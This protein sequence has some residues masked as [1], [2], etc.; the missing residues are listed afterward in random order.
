MNGQV[1]DIAGKVT[2]KVSVGNLIQQVLRSG[3]LNFRFSRRGSALE[4]MAGHRRIQR[5]RPPGYESE[6]TIKGVSETEDFRLEI[7]GRIDGLFTNSQPVMIEEIKTL[8]IPLSELADVNRLLHWGQVKI[9]AYLYAAQHDLAA[10]VVQ[11]CY[12]NLDDGEITELQ[13]CYSLPELEEFYQHVVEAYLEWLQTQFRW[14]VCRNASIAALT[15]PYGEYREGQRELAVSAYRAMLSGSQLYAQAPTGI[16][17]TM[18]TL[19]PAIK[20]L[21]EGLHDQVFYLTA[22]TVGRT[23]VEKALTELNGKGLRFKAITLTAKEKICFTP[24]APCDAEHCIYAR[25]YYDRNKPAVQDTLAG[26]DLVTRTVIEARAE[27]HQICPFE[28]S[29]D[30]S[31][32]MD[33]IIC[34]YNYVFDPTVYLRRFFDE[35]GGNYAFLIDEAHNLVDRGREMFSA[36]LEKDSLMTLKRA[37]AGSLPLVA[38]K[39]EKVN[40]A[41]LAILKDGREALQEVGHL[42]S[43]KPP[44]N[45]IR[46][47]TDFCKLAEGWLAENE[48]TAFHDD[49]LEFYFDSL[50]FIRTAELFD[51]HFVSLLQPVGYKRRVS[52]KITLYCINPARLLREGLERGKS[53]ILFSA[54]LTPDD[55][56]RTLLG[57]AEDAQSIRL[58]SPFPSENLGV[59]VVRRISTTYRH[60]QSSYAQVVDMIAEV[61]TSTK[62]NFLVYFPSYR[63]LQEVAIRFTER[64]PGVEVLMQTPQMGEGAREE[65]LHQL[66]PDRTATLVGFAVMGGIF[67]EGIDLEGQRLIGVVVVSVGLPQLGIEND[68]IM[69]HFADS[70]CGFEF[71]YQYPGMNRVL[72]TAGRVIRSKEDRG[73]ICLIDERFAHYRYR[74]LYPDE[75]TANFVDS[76]DELAGALSQFWHAG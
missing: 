22:K 42:V 72:Q 44:D 70:G 2:Y 74:K 59:Y 57:T 63:Y 16:G 56:Y 32:W 46:A 30:L 12:L 38:K 75:W 61:T 27:H 36:V 17:K 60:R 65:F 52:V 48:T 29:L 19:F 64:F 50:R 40:R 51:D 26:Y 53:T 7:G 5:S 68:L 33:C 35:D 49:L 20:A 66:Q 1:D 9:Y 71:A 76:R 47:L 55:Y 39:L 45:L 73:V 37:I 23:V 10:M 58:P 67:G 6:V 69:E 15:F 31:L 21:G 18:A 25:G 28:L 13:Q 24:G 4:G 8:R 43:E 41:F 14:K 3:D 54:T 11:L 34:D 62:G